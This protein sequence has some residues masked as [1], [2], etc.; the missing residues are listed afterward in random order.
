MHRINIQ[1]K[2]Q[3]CGLNKSETKELLS[4]ATKESLCKQTDTVAMGSLLLGITLALLYFYE[5]KWLEQFPKEFK[6]AC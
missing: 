2:W 4:L 6:P 3:C 1:S 5:K